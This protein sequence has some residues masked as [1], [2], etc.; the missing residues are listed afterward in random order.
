MGARG[1]LMASI[2]SIGNQGHKSSDERGGKC[3][4]FSWKIKELIDR[5]KYHGIFRRNHICIVVNPHVQ[6]L[7]ACFHHSSLPFC[8]SELSTSFLHIIL[9]L[10]I[11]KQ[12]L[13]DELFKAK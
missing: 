7:D 13:G 2:L 4:M 10:Q 8:F 12:Y 5:K 3:K 1:G 11:Q 9:S 6:G